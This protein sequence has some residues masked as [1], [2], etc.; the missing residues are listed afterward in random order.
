VELWMEGIERRDMGEL[1]CGT[2]GISNN[3]HD[4]FPIQPEMIILIGAVSTIKYPT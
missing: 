2:K 1:T 3:S 4:F